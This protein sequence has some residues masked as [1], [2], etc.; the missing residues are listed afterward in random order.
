MGMDMV[1]QE[2]VRQVAAEDLA[3]EIVA[4]IEEFIVLLAEVV[5]ESSRVRMLE[6]IMKLVL[7]YPL[8]ISIPI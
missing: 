6:S 3:V 4:E 7:G 2:V 8:S 5:V 1:I